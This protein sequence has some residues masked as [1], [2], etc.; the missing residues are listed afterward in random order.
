MQHC[1]VMVLLVQSGLASEAGGPEAGR[2]VAVCVAGA[3]QSGDQVFH[4]DWVSLRSL[5]GVSVLHLL[6]R[7]VLEPLGADVLFFLSHPPGYVPSADFQA[8]IASSPRV[9]LVKLDNQTGSAGWLGLLHRG[10]AE[11][12]SYLPYL[13]QGRAKRGRPFK[14]QPMNRQW[15]HCMQALRDIEGNRG[16]QY[17][18]VG[19]TRVDHAWTASHPSVTLLDASRCPGLPTVWSLDSHEYS[20]INDRYLIMERAG[21]PVM[22]AFVET[23]N[24]WKL[25][26]EVNRFARLRTSPAASQP[27]NYERF[28]LQMLRSAGLCIRYMTSVADHLAWP[29][30]LSFLFAQVWHQG[31]TWEVSQEPYLRVTGCEHVPAYCCRPDLLEFGGDLWC[32]HGLWRRHGKCR[33]QR[34]KLGLPKYPGDYVHERERIV[35]THC[36]GAQNFVRTCCQQPQHVSLKL[37]PSEQQLRSW[38]ELA[39]KDAEGLEDRWHCLH[40][41]DREWRALRPPWQLIGLAQCYDLGMLT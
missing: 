34:G 32:L 35:D 24:S 13:W 19:F 30:R 6:D 25:L 12:K 29:D 9:R 3:I 4:S 2:L 37:R 41:R 27:L 17:D 16:F 40:A 36:S 22:E 21:A 31:G 14:N 5:H 20:G 23:L 39:S 33:R 26:E 15:A 8:Y 11:N 18:Y 38:R 10:H 1:F 7:F 28:L